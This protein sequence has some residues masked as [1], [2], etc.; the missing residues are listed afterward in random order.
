[1]TRNRWGLNNIRIVVTAYRVRHKVNLIHMSHL[2][3]SS[4]RCSDISALPQMEQIGAVIHMFLPR[5][6]V[7]GR[8]LASSTKGLLQRGC[9]HK[10]VSILGR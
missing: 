9:N 6:C 10:G 5:V 1:M 8:L 2:L 3:T 7:D 4:V